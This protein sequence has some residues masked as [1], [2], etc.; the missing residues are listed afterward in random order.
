[1]SLWAVLP[2]KPLEKGKS[3]LHDCME[4]E[5]LCRLNRFLFEETF[6]KLRSC[7]SIDHVLVVSQD[8]N[9]LE[10]TRQSGGVALQENLLSSLNSAVTQALNHIL[11]IDPGEVLIV[12]ADLPWMTCEDL[13]DLLELRQDGKFMVIV[14]D[15]HQWGTNAILI[16]HPDLF[17]PQFGRHSFQK[18]C[19]QAAN[20]SLELV[21]WLNNNIQRDLDTPQDLITYNNVKIISTQKMTK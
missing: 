20:Q 11:E 13:E 16:S 18:H 5:E 21:V 8:E 12:P 7:G 15:W 19:R 17:T 6:Q 3:R 2:V 4:A 1:M 9:V 14:P 10:Y